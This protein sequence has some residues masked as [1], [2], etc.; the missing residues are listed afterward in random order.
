MIAL[1]ANDK[2]ANEDNQRNKFRSVI[3]TFPSPLFADE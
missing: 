3:H 1:T 2:K